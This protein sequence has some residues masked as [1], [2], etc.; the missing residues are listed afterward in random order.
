MGKNI[1]SGINYR[2]SRLIRLFQKAL[3]V[4][5]F[6]KGFARKVDFVLRKNSI[7]DSEY[8]LYQEFYVLA[9]QERV[10]FQVMQENISVDYSA[11]ENYPFAPSHFTHTGQYVFCLKDGRKIRVVIDAHDHPATQDEKI[12]EWA[13]VYFKIG[14]AHV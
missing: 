12:L 7:S 4:N 3:R 8:N 14:R 13:D 10:R 5:F 6:P 2:I 11:F 9:M 1:F